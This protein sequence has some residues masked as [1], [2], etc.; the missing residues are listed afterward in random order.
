MNKVLDAL[1]RAAAYCLYPPVMTLSLAPLGALI[2]VGLAFAFWGWQP[3]VTAI[4]GWLQ[5]G[6]LESMVLRGMQWIGME[7]HSR[8]LPAVIVLLAVLPVIVIVCLLV[9]TWLT[10]PAI[11]RIVSLRRFPDLERKHGGTLLAGAAWSTGYAL[12]ACALALLSLPLWLFPPLGLAIPPLIWGWL[13]A[14][15]LPYDVLAEHASKAER[16]VLLKR[17]RLEL[18]ALG[19]MTG[20]LGSAPS[21]LWASGTLFAGLLLILV[22]AAIWIYTLVFIFSTLWFSHFCL[23]ALELLRQENAASISND[24]ATPDGGSPLVAPASPPPA[25][26]YHPTIP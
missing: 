10:T 12:L 22:P 2:A 23:R 20:L 15:V 19:V 24:A 8:L 25:L 7:Q 16:R 18:L 1:W 21:L 17:Y 5:G 11:V 3:S 4:Q 26:P 6:A 13:T 9:V 14:R